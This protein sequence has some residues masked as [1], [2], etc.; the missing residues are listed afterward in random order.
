MEMAYRERWE[1]EIAEI[2]S[3]KV[4]LTRIYVSIYFGDGGAGKD[5]SE[6]R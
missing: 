1:A 3:S 2:R 4:A 5:L 6:R